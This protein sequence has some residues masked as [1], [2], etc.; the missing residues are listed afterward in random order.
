[1][2][3]RNNLAWMQKTLR[4]LGRIGCG[5]FL[6]SILASVAL[7]VIEYAMAIFLMVFLF[8]LG[9]VDYSNLPGWLPIDVRTTPPTAIWLG[10]F[11]I[12]VI[13]GALQ[14]VNYQ[15]RML[16]TERTQ[17]RLRMVLGHI[18]FTKPGTAQLPLSNINFYFGELFPKAISFIFHFTQMSSFFVQALMISVGMF[19]F[20]RGETLVGLAG[21]SLIGF[22][23]LKLNRHTHRIAKRVPQASEELERVKVRAVRNW[24]LIKILRTEHNEYKRY[25]TAVLQYYRHRCMA[26][27][28]GNSGA[29]LIPMFGVIV[30]AVIVFAN[31]HYFNTPGVDLVAF[32]YLF[33]RFMQML[34]HGSAM[35]GDLFAWRVQ[36]RESIELVGRLPR[37]ELHAAFRPAKGLNLISGRINLSHIAP[38]VNGARPDRVSAKPLEPPP[39]IRVKH[40][41]FRWPDANR[42]VLQDIRLDIPRGGQVGITGPNGSGKSTLLAIVLG[43]IEPDTGTVRIDGMTAGEYLQKYSDRVGY[44]GPESFLIEGTIRQNLHY[45][46]SEKLSDDELIEAFGQ[47]HLDNIVA[48]SGKGLDY[49]IDENGAGL[50][51]GQKQRLTIARAFLRKPKLLVMDEPTA[52]IDQAAEDLLASTLS[53]LKDRCTVIIVSHK[54]KVLEHVDFIVEMEADDRRSE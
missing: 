10:L 32:L 25:A 41:A 24:L 36:F 44:V 22:L 18:I 42:H 6:I 38:L 46:C 12:M 29:S 30:I 53:T 48:S 1:M 7:S 3:K 15:S 35:L 51:S 47:V 11:A 43:V 14:I 50:S 19:Y 4:I 40:V 33:F 13:R 28:I 49:F 26:Y 31:A 37:A 8:T 27:L 20:A 21:L 39:A 16:L 17:S 54:R 45:G 52:N 23:V 9:F 2:P 34:A 5:L